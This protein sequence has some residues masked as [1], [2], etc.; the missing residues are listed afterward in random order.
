LA[1]DD[2]KRQA[3]QIARGLRA[4]YPQAVCALDY[5][6]P[7]QLLIATILSAQCTDKRVNLVTPELFRRYPTA[8]D[9]AAAP[10]AD[11]E[12]AI[13]STGFFRNKAKS[14]QGC[15]RK[16]ADDF[17][18]KVPET[19]EKVNETCMR[20]ATGFPFLIPGSNSH[21]EIA[22]MAGASNSLRVEETTDTSATRPC[23][24]TV[25]DIVTLPLAPAR[26]KLNG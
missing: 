1:V 2:V 9:F 26:D 7:L 16:L 21:F 10:L 22:V 17:D 15:C 14:I 25:N 6:T 23:V 19:L 11:L 13:Q 12:K 5:Q 3:R 8:A 4:E 24:L 20:A 18:G